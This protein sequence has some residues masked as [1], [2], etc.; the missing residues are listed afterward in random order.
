MNQSKLNSVLL[1]VGIVVGGGIGGWL[2]SKTDK[3]NDLLIQV[4]T[5]LSEVE[6]KLGDSVSRREFDGTMTVV[7]TRLTGVETEVQRIKIK[8]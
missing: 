6:R 8:N 5:R 1:S 2:L 7:N 4:N 3:N